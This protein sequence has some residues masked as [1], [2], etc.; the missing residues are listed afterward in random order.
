MSKTEDPRTALAAL[1]ATNDRL[2]QR[3]S[4][5]LWRHVAGGLL[6]S[7]I[8]AGAGL[9]RDI[10]FIVFFVA[11]VLIVV[12]VR[13]DKKRHGMFVSGYQRGRT[14]WIVAIMIALTLAA[15][16]VIRTQVD[17]G[18]G[19]PWFWATLAILFCS[20]TMLSLLWERVYRDDI[21]DGSL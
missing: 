11:M 19:S 9:P 7:L 5:P 20:I 21:R 17:G 3:M 10:A 12:I 1:E 14:K 4:W 16:I 8:V 6:M 15:L 2:A 13:D 18:A